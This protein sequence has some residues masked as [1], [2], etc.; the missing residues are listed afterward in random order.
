MG[1]SYRLEDQPI[2][3]GLGARAMAQP[4]FTGMEWY[5]AYSTRTATDG[6]EGRLVSLYNFTESWNSWERHPAGDEVVICLEGSMTLIQECPDGH[7]DALV[8][9]AG[10]YTIVAPGV[11]HTADLS[12]PATAL[13]IT[14]GTGT[15]HRPR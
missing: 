3:L 15:E 10:N 2:H 9:G 1:E 11:W 13:F 14:A 6:I 8:L 7:T 4:A 5:G 12:E